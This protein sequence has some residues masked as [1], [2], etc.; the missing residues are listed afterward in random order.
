LQR[1]FSFGTVFKRLCLV[2]KEGGSNWDIGNIWYGKFEEKVAKLLMMPFAYCPAFELYVTEAGKIKPANHLFE[3]CDEIL[4]SNSV[5]VDLPQS[6]P[7]LCQTDS[8]HGCVL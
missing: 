8:F 7:P 5:G 3:I 6:A 1:I 2:V 4:L